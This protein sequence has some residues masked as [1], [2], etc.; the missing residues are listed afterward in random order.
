MPAGDIVRYLNGRLFVAVG[1]TLY[2][3]EPY[4]LALRSPTRNYIQ[5][6]ERITVLEPVDNGFFI[7][8][9]KTYWVAGDVVEAQLIPV[10]PYGGVF[11]TGG[12]IPHD[13]GAAFWMSP[14]GLVRGDQDGSV[15]NLQE[16]NVAVDPA[17]LGA[18]AF[19]ERDGMK[20]AVASLFGAEPTQMTA[21][22]YMD[23]EIVRKGTTI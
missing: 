9:D 3:S 10:L 16:Q 23:A 21:H 7:A 18:T 14:R 8:A 19:V 4:S 12:Q 22:S 15:K 13:D 20:Q 11:G 1:S 17:V 5:F 6:P 2:Y